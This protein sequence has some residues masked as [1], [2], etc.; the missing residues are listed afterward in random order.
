MIRKYL[1]RLPH[2]EM[3]SAYYFITFHALHK[4]F[5]D[6]EIKLI[7]DQIISGHNNYYDLIAVQV[8]PDHVHLILKLIDK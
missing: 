4:R 2:W 5:S 1:H 3:E 8:M 7:R 6:E